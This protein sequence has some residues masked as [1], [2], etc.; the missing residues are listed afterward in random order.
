MGVF[1]L[2][3]LFF[4]ADALFNVDGSFFINLFNFLPKARSLIWS[5]K[6]INQEKKCLSQTSIRCYQ[7]M[8]T[9]TTQIALNKL[10]ENLTLCL[11]GLSE[12][13]LS[14]TRDYAARI[15]GGNK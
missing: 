10:I 9:I 8:N 5:K 3:L 11:L 4:I 13:L 15:L 1:F 14:T 12:V 6:Y 7:L 2:L